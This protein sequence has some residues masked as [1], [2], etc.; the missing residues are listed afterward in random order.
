MS[1]ATQTLLS[2]SKIDSSKRLSATLSTTTDHIQKKHVN[3]ATFMQNH[4]RALEGKSGHV[5]QDKNSTLLHK[6]K[7]DE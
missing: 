3:S 6:D 2:K 5:I 1:A 7:S 4:S